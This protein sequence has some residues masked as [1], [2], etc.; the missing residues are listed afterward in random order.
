[1]IQEALDN[2]IKTNFKG[3]RV[4]SYRLNNIINEAMTES[5]KNAFAKDPDIK[6][7]IV[8]GIQ[9]IANEEVRKIANKKVP[10]WVSRQMKEMLKYARAS[11]WDKEVD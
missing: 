5:V 6:Q 4:C 11:F 7:M 10:G 9:T 2:Y 1:L 8:D 3:E